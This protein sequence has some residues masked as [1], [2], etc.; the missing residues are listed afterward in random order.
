MRVWYSSARPCGSIVCGSKPV[1]MRSGAA[2]EDI[3]AET[4]RAQRTRSKFMAASDDLEVALQFPI[5]HAVEPL[6]P[7]PFAGRGEVI[8]EGIAEPVARDRRLLEDSRGLDQRAR[9]ARHVF[10]ALVGAG[11]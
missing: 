9:R 3:T 5:G 11:D 1:A 7:L 2:C 6:A 10:G 4:Q 8:D